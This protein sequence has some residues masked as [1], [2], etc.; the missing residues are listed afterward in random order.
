MRTIVTLPQTYLTDN[1]SQKKLH[2]VH[3]LKTKLQLMK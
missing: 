1:S 2:E 3:I